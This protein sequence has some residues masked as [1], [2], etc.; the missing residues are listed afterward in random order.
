MPK[1]LTV[2]SGKGGVG[3]TNV[4]VNLSLALKNQGFKTCL[5]DADLG[6]ANANILLG[7]YP[8]KNLEDV[9]LNNLPLRDIV[10]R[11]ADGLELIPGS[12]GIEVMANLDDARVKT[13]LKQLSDLTD[14]DFL[15]LDCSS[16]IARQTISF[17]LAASEVILVFTPEPTSLVDAFAMLKVLLANEPKLRIR[18]LINN[19]PDAQSA[20]VAFARMKQAASQYLDFYLQPLG[21][22]LKDSHVD[23]AIRRQR[24]LVNLYPQAVAARCLKLVAGRLIEEFRETGSGQ[25]LEDFWARFFEVLH[26]PLLM[27]GN[28]PD[29]AETDQAETTQAGGDEAGDKT[30]EGKTAEIRDAEDN[31]GEAKVA[32]AQNT[33]A[34]LPGQPSARPGRPKAL[35]PHLL[36]VCPYALLAAIRDLNDADG[37]LDRLHDLVR[38]DPGLCLNILARARSHPDHVPADVLS[39]KA[40]L[41]ALGWAGTRGLVFHLAALQVLTA[42]TESEMQVWGNVISESRRRA[43]LAEA[44]AHHFDL[45][46]P[47]VYLAGLFSNL[48]GLVEAPAVG[49]GLGGVGPGRRAARG[50][51]VLENLGFPTLFADAIRYADEGS[52]RV[53]QALPLVQA[54]HLACGLAD[55]TLRV[56]QMNDPN[57]ELSLDWEKAVEDSHRE[58]LKGLGLEESE[59]DRPDWN[60]VWAEV[61]V[62]VRTMVLETGALLTA[63]GMDEGSPEAGHTLAGL[64]SELGARG[65]MLFYHQEEKD[66]LTAGYYQGHIGSELLNQMSIPA[67]RGENV[68]VRCWM[69]G[70]ACHSLNHAQGKERQLVDEQLRRLMKVEALCCFLLS[71]RGEPMGVLVMGCDA[72]D[73]PVVLEHPD[74]PG[75][76]NRSSRLLAGLMDGPNKPLSAAV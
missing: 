3:K 56:D 47:E 41:E 4:S 72:K 27:P 42:R 13:T 17:C 71:R 66:K 48:A 6:L 62:E 32:E 59:S 7:L 31:S 39:L 21:V 73:A 33:V 24:P 9:V 45:A 1:I 51:E 50:A 10:V 28:R 30:A 65:V 76:V 25:S 75:L 22:V 11:T 70:R 53:Q 14:Y 12:S 20:K 43:R 5:F 61:A 8:E 15:I 60:R 57:L 58:G 69:S 23:E 2:A 52:D 49:D 16:G 55:G 44:L 26:Q 35:N 18:A 34:A 37:S 40:A 68:I 63:S 74:L 36:P 38:L 46:R 29:Q 64:A 19:C 67:D 54:V